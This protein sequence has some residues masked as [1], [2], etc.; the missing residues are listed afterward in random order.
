MARIELRP[1]FEADVLASA[2][3]RRVVSDRGEKVATEAERLAGQVSRTYTAEVEQSAA[4][5]RVGGSTRATETHM[6]LGK[7]IEHGNWKFPAVA[8]LRRGAEAIGLKAGPAR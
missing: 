5:V 1:G 6:N 2:G 7:A 4:G 3:V 8:P